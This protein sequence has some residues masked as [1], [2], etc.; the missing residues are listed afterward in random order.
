MKFSVAASLAT[1]ATLATTAIAGNDPHSVCCAALGADG[2]LRGKVLLPDSVQYDAQLNTYYSANAAQHA[3]CMVLPESTRDVQAIVKIL[4]KNQCPFGIKAGGHSAFKGSNGIAEGVTVDFGHLNS[5]SYNPDT[6]IVSMQPGA[7]WGSVYETLNPYNVAVVGAR[8]S[9]VGVGGFAT[10]SGTGKH[11]LTTFW[12][13]FHAN[14]HGFT[15]DAV[16]NWEIVLAN[17]SVVNANS[18]ENA[19]LWKAQKGGSGNL[20]FVTLVEQKVVEG[21]QLWGG[22]TSYE[23]SERDN[24]FTEYLDFVEKTEE[25]SPDQTI[26]ALYFDT[27]GFS[28]RS[29]LT[30]NKGIAN[31]PAFDGFLAL[32]NI[33]STVTS[34]SISD[35]IPHA[36]WFTGMTTNTF[37]ALTIIDDLHH[38]YIPLMQAAAPNSNFS[39]LVELQPVT[40]SM[41]DN[42]VAR[43]GNILGL[44]R[45]VKDGPVLMW[46]VS[47]TVDTEE[48]QNAI[49][50]I[51]REFID[52]IN[53]AEKEAGH[54]IDWIYLNYAWKD[55]KPYSHYG[56]DN[57]KLLHTVS[58][59]YD[60]DGVF[61][62]LRRTGF[63]L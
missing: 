53:K 44:E 22:F 19:D 49:L 47:L 42:S 12:Y 11:W 26:I 13:S 38:K 17:G 43:G 48:N 57:I 33:S 8:A 1:L 30:N 54:W 56:K 18:N 52:A 3:W 59:K 40:N 36:N 32:P 45:V 4:T 25:N 35:I 63:R 34:G 14:S 10:G 5:T 46:L 61:Q 27:T 62:K 58:K 50:P 41:V 55:Q 6:R 9:V 24:V 2:Q 60:H 21:T 29:I 15:C 16:E 23:L 31:A 39:T 28:I 51:A 20:G 7:K 37:E